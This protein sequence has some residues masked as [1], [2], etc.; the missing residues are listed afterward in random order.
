MIK[1]LLPIIIGVVAMGSGVGC[2]MSSIDTDEG[3]SGRNTLNT[4]GFVL[5]R[6]FISASDGSVAVVAV[7]RGL[8]SFARRKL[9]PV[10]S[11]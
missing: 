7:V 9:A 10:F 5:R 2:W 4:D 11:E 6:G 3:D 8:L 1:N